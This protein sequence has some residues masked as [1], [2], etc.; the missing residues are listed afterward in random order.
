MSRWP[1]T[2]WRRRPG[3]ERLTAT[4]GRFRRAAVPTGAAGF[5]VGREEG[6][7]LPFL[8]L[9]K[10][11][12]EQFGRVETARRVKGRSPG[13]GSCGWQCR[14]LLDRWY[15]RTSPAAS[16][17]RRTTGSRCQVAQSSGARSSAR[18]APAVAAMTRPSSTR[19]PERF[20]GSSGRRCPRPPGCSRRVFHAPARIG[21]HVQI[22]NRPGLPR[23]A[24]EPELLGG[25]GPWKLDWKRLGVSCD[26]LVKSN[27]AFMAIFRLRAALPGRRPLRPWSVPARRR[28]SRSRRLVR[29][30]IKVRRNWSRWTLTPRS[31]RFCR[32]VT[33]TRRLGPVDH[34]AGS[35]CRGRAF[36]G[37]SPSW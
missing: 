2:W 25:C 10:P 22:D 26:R 15:G 37:G 3:A 30:R 9:G 7:V 34:C 28:R 19:P 27:G 29:A 36:P 33:A 4:A 18:P 6:D 20:V 11:G 32:S 12:E 24:A 23:F 14:Q 1:G 21:G 5:V 13:S 16:R 35:A 31:S 17:G 8:R